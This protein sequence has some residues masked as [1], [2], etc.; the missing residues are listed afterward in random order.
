MSDRIAVLSNG[1]IEQIGSPRDIYNRPAT[2]FVADFIGVSNQMPIIGAATRQGRTF[3]L[4]EGGLELALP[5][6]AAGSL[7]NA[8]AVVRPERSEEHTSE[9]QSLMRT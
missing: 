2:R 3:A 4:I 1:R 9:L 5:E 7:V 8:T 6:A